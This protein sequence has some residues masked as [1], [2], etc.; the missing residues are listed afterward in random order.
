MFVRL[1][2]KGE[3]TKTLV[4]SQFRPP[5]NTWSIE[6]PAGLIDEGETPEEAARRELAE[7]T[8]YIASDG[9]CT[10]VFPTVIAISKECSLK[11][12]ISPHLKTKITVLTDVKLLS[13]SWAVTLSYPLANDPGMS[14]TTQILCIATVDLDDPRNHNA[15]P[16]ADDEFIETHFVEL[17]ALLSTIEGTPFTRTCS[18]HAH[19]KPHSS[20]QPIFLDAF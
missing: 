3:T 9:T 7:E 11:S 12:G 17:P 18:L 5:L 1:V 15:K 13:P 16:R 19:S 6:F 2:K 4:I 14:N 8:G 20:H 10:T